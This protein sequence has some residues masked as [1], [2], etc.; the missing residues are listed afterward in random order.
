MTS[1]DTPYPKYQKSRSEE[2]EWFISPLFLDKTKG[3]LAVVA[4]GLHK[5]LEPRTVEALIRKATAGP[6]VADRLNPAKA[7][8]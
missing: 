5:T 6:S 7:I 8:P 3:G 2:N 1:F 4:L